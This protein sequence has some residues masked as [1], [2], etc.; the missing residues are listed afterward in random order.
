[1]VLIG[2]GQI[3]CAINPSDIVTGLIDDDANEDA[4]VTVTSYRGRFPFKTEQ[5]IL[6]KKGRKFI[7]SAILKQI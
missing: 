4:I 1:M 5:L 3:T 7:L 2:D 6:I